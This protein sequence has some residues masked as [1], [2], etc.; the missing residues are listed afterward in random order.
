[1]SRSNSAAKC[2]A[3]RPLVVV[4]AGIGGGAVDGDFAV[5]VTGQR[6]EHGRPERLAT[7]RCVGLA[8]GPGVDR[9][10]GQVRG[11]LAAAGGAVA[12]FCP[13]R[14]DIAAHPGAGDLLVQV[15]GPLVEVA[16]V[17]PG[18]VG[19]VAALLGFGAV[20]DP[21]ELLVVGVIRGDDGF[22]VEVPALAALRC[23]QG[24]GPLGAAGAH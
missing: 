12:P 4:A 7:G 19:L 6:D 1:M 21:H 5:A 10:A 15:A 24:P 18:G 9:T 20:L 17:T 22:M 13:V 16:R 11:V 8:D 14:E 2:S 23:S 3:S